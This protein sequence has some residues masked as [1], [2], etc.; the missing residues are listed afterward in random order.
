VALS[1]S[2]IGEL[3]P[4]ISRCVPDWVKVKRGEYPADNPRRGSGAAK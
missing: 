3:L 2:L 1:S 4:E